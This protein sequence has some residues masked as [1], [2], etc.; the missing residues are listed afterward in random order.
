MRSAKTLKVSNN[1]PF[2]TLNFIDCLDCTKFATICHSLL[3]HMFCVAA[4]RKEISDETDRET[5]RS[6][7]ISAVPIYLSI[8]SPNGESVVVIGYFCFLKLTC[9]CLYQK[10]LKLTCT[11]LVILYHFVCIESM[12]IQGILMC[13]S[14][15]TSNN[16]QPNDSRYVTS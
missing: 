1:V 10:L 8:Y 14:G 6:K 7:Q 2:C 4:V 15:I 11:C 3:L 9:T 16:S 12:S 13:N 5:G